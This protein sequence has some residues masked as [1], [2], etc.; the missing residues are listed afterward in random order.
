VCILK[1]LSDNSISEQKYEKIKHIKPLNRK[2]RIKL[3]LL[4]I[5]G[6]LAK[7]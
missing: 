2:I 3:L 5:V 4:E 1:E 6:Q 7:G